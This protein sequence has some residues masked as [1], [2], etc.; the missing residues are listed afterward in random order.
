MESRDRD[1]VR[2]GGENRNGK[3][4]SF[5]VSKGVSYIRSLP[6]PGDLLLP[7]VLP[8]SAYAGG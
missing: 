2:T 6:Y 7:L 1:R 4:V 5:S 8:Q 3:I